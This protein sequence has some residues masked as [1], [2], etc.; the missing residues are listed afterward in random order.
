MQ[1]SLPSGSA[2]TTQDTSGP[3]PTSARTAP[4][5]SSRSTSSC[6]VLPSEA[7]RSRCSRFLT[8]LSSGTG[9]MSISGPAPPSARTSEMTSASLVSRI[10]YP[11]APVQ[12]CASRA[13]SAASRAMDEMTLLMERS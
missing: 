1:N 5:A 10:R 4:R 12:N 8:V 3:W 9:M 6:C 7:R 2:S 13:G 11:S